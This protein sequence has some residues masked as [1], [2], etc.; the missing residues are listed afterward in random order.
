MEILL[1][2]SLLYQS[3][4]SAPMVLCIHKNTGQVLEDLHYQEGI[5][6]P[7]ADQDKY[8]ACQKI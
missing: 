1:H 2:Q 5:V 8:E 7:F 4:K 6:E 3:L